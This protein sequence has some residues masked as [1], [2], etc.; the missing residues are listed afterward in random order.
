MNDFYDT[1]KRE[2]IAYC[3]ELAADEPRVMYL[4]DTECTVE[5]GEDERTLS[6]G[7]EIPFGCTVTVRVALNLRN[8]PEPT[9]RLGLVHVWKGGYLVK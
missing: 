6:D 9:R 8:R 3:T 2:I 7:D 1:L 4:A 5:E